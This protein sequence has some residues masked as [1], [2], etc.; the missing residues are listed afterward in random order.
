MRM[1]S[2]LSGGRESGAVGEAGEERSGL[3]AAGFGA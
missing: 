2:V 1:R 3:S